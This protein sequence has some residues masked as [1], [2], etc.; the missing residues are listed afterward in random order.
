MLRAEE[1]HTRTQRFDPRALAAV[2]LAGM[3]VLNARPKLLSKDSKT[4]IVQEV[5]AQSIGDRRALSCIPRL[6]PGGLHL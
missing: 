2:S 5:R 4:M 3:L 1:T 6:L